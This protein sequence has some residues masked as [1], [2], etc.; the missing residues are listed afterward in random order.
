VQVRPFRLLGASACSRL[1]A[2]LDPVLQAWRTDWMPA[3]SAGINAT[4]RVQ[5]LDLAHA[6]SHP[7]SEPAV[8]YSVPDAGACLLLNVTAQRRALAAEWIPSNDRARR[9]T[10]PSPMS[11]ALAE[12]ALE[13]LQVRLLGTRIDLGAQALPMAERDALLA[14]WGRAGSGAASVVITLGACVLSFLIDGRR[15][16]VGGEAQPKAVQGGL[17]PR[18]AGVGNA[19]LR[20]RAQLGHASLAIESLCALQPG[21]VLRIDQRLDAPLVLTTERGEPVCHGHLF[22]VQGRRAI[23]VER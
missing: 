9:V 8:L 20:L 18:Q 14:A 19:R 13:A 21:D 10:A 6:A 15:A 11:E 22:S 3:T 1:E 17:A 23:V 16:A 5:P 7:G 4:L 12:R 2:Q